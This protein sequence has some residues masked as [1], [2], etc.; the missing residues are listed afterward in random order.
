ME[1]SA[2]PPEIIND[3]LSGIWSS[4][5]PSQERI[6]LMTTC[7]LLN[8]TWKAVFARIASRQIYILPTKFFEYLCSITH[9]QTSIVYGYLLPNTTRSI[10]CQPDLDS[11]ATEMYM[12]LCKQ[13]NF[14]G[15]RTYF[16]NVQKLRL[17]LSR[18][19]T[20]YIKLVHGVKQVVHT[21]IRFHM[22]SNPRLTTVRTTWSIVMHYDMGSLSNLPEDFDSQRWHADNVDDCL[23]LM[24][25]FTLIGFQTALTH[26]PSA[27]DTMGVVHD[28]DH[29][30][31][32]HY[33]KYDV[34]RFDDFRGFNWR[35]CKAIPVST[36]GKLWRVAQL[37][38]QGLV[39]RFRQCARKYDP[40]LTDDWPINRLEWTMYPTE[41]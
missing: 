11:S 13:R 30:I 10:T 15:L 9:S 36:K 28:E 6:Q 22:D 19:Q 12:T 16:P 3:I 21:K 24:S 8:S 31:R 34:E 2:L 1:S 38:C 39:R 17:R 41:V 27:G 32:Y 23:W 20:H 4:S 40:Y 7:S 29:T 14:I 35:L 26:Y 18:R 33:E 5:M 37:K 25:P